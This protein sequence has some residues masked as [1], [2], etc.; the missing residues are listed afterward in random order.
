MGPKRWIEISKT[1]K[2]KEVAEM[3][4]NLLAMRSKKTFLLQKPKSQK[5]KQ[6]EAGE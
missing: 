2:K 6:K 4:A 1:K 5:Q 3:D